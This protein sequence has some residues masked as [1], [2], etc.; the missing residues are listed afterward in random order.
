MRKKTQKLPKWFEGTIYKEGDI[1]HN[2][3]SGESYTL[4]NI[5]LSMYDFIMGSVQVFEMQEDLNKFDGTVLG[6]DFR[7]NL[8]KSLNWFKKNNPKAYMAL[9]D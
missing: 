1:V 4:N 9:L 5:E 8:K 3:Y 7:K 6:K 2:R